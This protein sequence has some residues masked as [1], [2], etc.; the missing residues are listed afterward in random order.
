MTITIYW[1]ATEE[2]LAVDP[3]KIELQRPINS[4]RELLLETGLSVKY[5]TQS[6]ITRLKSGLYR[7]VILYR[8]D[9]NKHLDPQIV[10]FG[11]STLDIRS[12]ETSGKA[13]W[14][15]A[16]DSYYNGAVNWVSNGLQKFLEKETIERIKRKQSK[17]KDA[18]LK[19]DSRCAISGESTLDVLEAAHIIPSSRRGA[20]TPRNGILLRAD[21]HRLFDKG[22]FKITNN[23]EIRLMRKVSK[24]YQSL[25]EGACLERAVTERIS[26]ALIKLNKKSSG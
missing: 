26:D 19:L 23:G 13:Q 25:L 4:T 21:L 9:A 1:D 6:S 20:E 7:L 16:D 18:L 15:D 2:V 3:G 14:D 22:I 10:R 8:R 11:K 12:A 5:K 24:P 17:F